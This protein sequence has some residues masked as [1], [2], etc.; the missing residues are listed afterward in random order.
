MNSSFQ[1]SKTTYSTGRLTTCIQ[2]ISLP[3]K[4]WKIYRCFHL[5]ATWNDLRTFCLDKPESWHSPVWLCWTHDLL[6]NPW[7]AGLFFFCLISISPVI[8]REISFRKEKILP[9]LRS[10]VIQFM[11]LIQAG[12]WGNTRDLGWVLVALK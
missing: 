12:E 3:T 11:A 2:S 8:F 4:T 1:T 7:L 9:W 6:W 10:A 5:S